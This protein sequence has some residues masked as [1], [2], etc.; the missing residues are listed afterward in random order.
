MLMHSIRRG[1]GE[2]LQTAAEV[3]MQALVRGA[4]LLASACC[5]RRAICGITSTLS[6]AQQ[7][8][9][10]GHWLPCQGELTGRMCDWLA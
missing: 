10:A 8:M 5:N 1:G 6:P 4:A 2:R 7:L 3:H 9:V